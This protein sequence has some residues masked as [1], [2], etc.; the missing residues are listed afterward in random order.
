[1][2]VEVCVIFVMDAV[3]EVHPAAEIAAERAVVRDE[4][5][6]EVGVVPVKA[7]SGRE[8]RENEPVI[9]VVAEV[10][11]V[12]VRVIEGV[13]VAVLPVEVEEG[14]G[15]FPAHGTQV[16][17]VVTTWLWL[18]LPCLYTGQLIM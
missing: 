10:E 18:E 16:E 7:E 2:P 17:S 15:Q 13:V 6:A 14:S 12:T 3:H 1:M 11:G 8:E 9:V 5:V 4:I